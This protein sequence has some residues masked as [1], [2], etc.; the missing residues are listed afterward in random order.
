MQ[1]ELWQIHAGTM[2]TG[3]IIVI[4]VALI[5]RFL[6]GKNW[7]LRVHKSVASIGT[8]TVLAGF[9]VAFYMVTTTSG[10][11]FAYLH[12]YMGLTSVTLALITTIT[13]YARQRGKLKVNRTLF[14]R[15]HISLAVL[16]A[17]F[18]TL[19]IYMGLGLV[20]G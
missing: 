15:L 9:S 7:W 20:Y 1:I 12:S 11:H 4:V 18:M 13:G 2:T 3:L 10:V 16:T 14:R 19:T 8:L 5:A 6:R 17:S